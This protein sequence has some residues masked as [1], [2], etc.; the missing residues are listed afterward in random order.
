MG[1][2]AFILN[3]RKESEADD[4]A[5]ALRFIRANHEKLHVEEDKIA[6]LTFGE[7]KAAA[8]KLFFHSKRI[9]DVTHRYDV[10]K[11][12]PEELWIMGASDEDADKT[13]VFFSGSH[14][15]LADDSREWLETRIRKLS[16]NAEIEEKIN[17]GEQAE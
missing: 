8:R 1:C 4:M 11:C 10:L 12:E 2:Q 5:R 14:Y 9:K 3:L 15:S 7:M 17:E 6:L 16:E 13:G